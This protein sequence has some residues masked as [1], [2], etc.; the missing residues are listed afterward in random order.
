MD[1]ISRMVEESA[2]LD[3]ESLAGRIETSIG[4]ILEAMPAYAPPLNV[5]HM[6]MY[7]VERARKKHSSGQELRQSIL[8]MASDYRMWSNDARGKIS[9]HGRNLISPHSKV[10]TF[11]LSETVLH[12]LLT[13]WEAGIEFEVLITESR[14]NNDGL[15]SLEKLSDKGIRVHV[16]ID[17]S[18]SELISRADIMLAGAEAILA[19]GS[20][21]CKVGTYPC[22]LLAQQFGVPVY[23]VV[24]TMK[25]DISSRSGVRMPMDPIRP[26]DLPMPVNYERVDVVGHLFDATP[27]SLIH[28][29]VTEQGILQASECAALI[30]QRHMSQVLSS[31]ISDRA[32]AQ[33]N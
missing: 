1:V 15:V 2:E 21:I 22:A 33:R 20:A 8:A 7:E 23:I 12:T 5:M 16:G 28:G 14:P 29:I 27:P 10:F 25:F 13:A 30:N 11:T 18:I 17:A 32:R 19:D 24:D 26:R 3:L 6:V 4:A 9:L 31:H